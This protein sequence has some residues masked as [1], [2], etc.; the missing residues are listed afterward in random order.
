[1]PPESKSI[2]N[3]PDAAIVDFSADYG[4]AFERLNVEWL[5]KYF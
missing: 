4:D 3:R 5:E 1:V 2:D